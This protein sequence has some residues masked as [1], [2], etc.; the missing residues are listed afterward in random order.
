MAKKATK[1]AVV[2]EPLNLKL[3]LGCGKNKQPN[4]I[5][6]DVI[7]FPGVDQVVDL[8]KAPWPWP[9]GSVEHVYCSHMI[10]HLEWPDRVTFFNELYRVLRLGGQCTLV[11]PNW[12]HERFWGDPTHKA[13]MSTFAM[14]YLSKAWRESQSP[15]VGY[16]CDFAVTWGHGMDTDKI[17]GRNPEYVQHAATHFI[18]LVADI[19]AT[20]T[21]T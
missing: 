10:E 12:A 2:P 11:W 14:Y 7:A 1:L 20:L 16:T 5:G 13:P 21:K 8:R 15:H 6:V 17:V 19:H 4:F 3:D 9:D 18:N